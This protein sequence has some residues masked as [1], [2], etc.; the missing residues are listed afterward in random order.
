MPCKCSNREKN[1][2]LVDK[3]LNKKQLSRLAEINKCRLSEPSA[4]K[5]VI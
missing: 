4:K 2:V 5:K 3:P 1:E